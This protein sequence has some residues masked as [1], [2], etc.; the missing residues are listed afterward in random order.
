MAILVGRTYHLNDECATYR[1]PGISL[2][3]KLVNGCLRVSIS[4]WF[5]LAK[6]I[7]CAKV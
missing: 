2:H 6:I 1:K 5:L 3:Q 7:I 4:G